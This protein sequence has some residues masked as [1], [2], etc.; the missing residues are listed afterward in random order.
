MA[1]VEVVLRLYQEAGDMDFIRAVP[2]ESDTYR[3]AV[4]QALDYAKHSGGTREYIV[5]KAYSNIQLWVHSQH[6][7]EYTEHEILEALNKLHARYDL[8]Q[9]SECSSPAYPIA[10][11]DA[12]MCKRCAQAAEA[13]SEVHANKNREG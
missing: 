8:P 3:G 10:S 4:W 9:C 11:G 2:F 12:T 13:H 1:T 6:R 5:C 7:R